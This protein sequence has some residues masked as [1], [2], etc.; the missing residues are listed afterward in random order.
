[1][2]VV[3]RLKSAGLTSCTASFPVVASTMVERTVHSACDESWIRRHR[4]IVAVGEEVI[5]A[6]LLSI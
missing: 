6:D 4:A 1:M 5:S 3:G 2:C